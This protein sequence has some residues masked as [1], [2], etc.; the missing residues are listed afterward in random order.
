MHL[1]PRAVAHDFENQSTDHGSEVAPCAI[2]YTE[3][4]LYE[5]EQGEDGEVESIAGQGGII[6]NLSELQRAELEGAEVRVKVEGG[7]VDRHDV[8]SLG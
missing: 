8:D 5:E 2:P 7:L 6:A 4:G 3:K 1:D